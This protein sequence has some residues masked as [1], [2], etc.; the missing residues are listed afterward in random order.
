M[1]CTDKQINWLIVWFLCGLLAVADLTAAVAD[2]APAPPEWSAEFV[3]QVLADARA[4]GDA[5]RGA[6]VFSVATSACTSCHKVAGQGGIVGLCCAVVVI[7]CA[8]FAGGPACPGLIR[9]F[10]PPIL[11]CLREWPVT[12][13]LV[14]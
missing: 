9:W 1:L 2:Q 12:M 10:V 13:S 3:Q 5:R 11:Q 8:G 14:C 4:N 7:C 6:G